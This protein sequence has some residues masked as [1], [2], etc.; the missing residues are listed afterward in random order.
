MPRVKIAVRDLELRFLLSYD[1]ASSLRSH[2]GQL[3]RRV[4]GSWKP[5]YFTALR[6]ISFEVREGETVGLIGRNGAGKSTLLRTMAGI[7]H[8]DSGSVS[9]HGRVSAVLQL[10]VGFNNALSGRDNILLAGMM[11]GHTRSDM[12]ERMEEIIDFAELGEFIDQP[13]RFYSS[14][15][16]SRLSFAIATATEPDVLLL[17]E[18]LSVGDLAFA[19]KARDAMD[20]MRRRASCQMIVSHDLEAIRRLCDRALVL[21]AG[22]LVFDGD[23]SE[24]IATYTKRVESGAPAPPGAR[25]ACGSA[26][27]GSS[28]RSP[29]PWPKPGTEW[30]S[31]PCS[32]AP[33]PC[34]KRE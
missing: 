5:R 21:E 22:E 12:L 17:D 32:T 27:R 33:G 20:R 13:V 29:R 34:S 1:R 6:G 10:G 25:R 19:A 4:S 30:A 8:P 16:I 3:A 23:V 26:R 15:M 9:V 7:Y 18:T 31:R 14:G 11:L 24:A 28:G 2:L